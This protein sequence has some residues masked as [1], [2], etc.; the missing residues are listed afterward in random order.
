M[1]SVSIIHLFLPLPSGR[2]KVRHTCSITAFA[3]IFLRLRIYQ[4]SHLIPQGLGK[5]TQGLRESEKMA[6]VFCRNICIG[7]LTSLTIY[8]LPTRMNVFQGL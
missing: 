6:A 7:S 5:K 3:G 2:L 4:A 1:R 8:D